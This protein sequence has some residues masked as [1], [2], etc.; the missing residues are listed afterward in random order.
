MVLGSAF[1]N[2]LGWSFWGNGGLVALPSIHFPCSA[3]AKKLVF[4]V[5]CVTLSRD[6]VFHG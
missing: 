6:E 5:A 4:F 1:S 3:L 2:Y